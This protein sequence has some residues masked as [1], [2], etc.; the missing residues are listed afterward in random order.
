MGLQDLFGKC[1]RKYPKNSIICRD[2]EKGKEMF[3][4]LSGQVKI[5]KQGPPPHY[6]INT[7]ATVGPG[8]FFG[9]MSL[10]EDLPRYANAQAISEVN[11][12]VIDLEILMQILKMQPEFAIKI[13]QKLSKR[14]RKLDDMIIFNK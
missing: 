7:I 5:Y 4:I 8:D 9:E 14:I 12:L 3:I 11:V 13:L 1:G 2:K 10:L 6:R